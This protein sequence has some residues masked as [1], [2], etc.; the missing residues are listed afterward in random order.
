MQA[1][2]VSNSILS[3]QYMFTVSN[4]S[5]DLVTPEQYTQLVSTISQYHLIPGFMS[6]YI[7]DPW[8]IV[9]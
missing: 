3:Q 9:I 6:D 1:Y 2:R 5:H 4:L 7:D 8:D